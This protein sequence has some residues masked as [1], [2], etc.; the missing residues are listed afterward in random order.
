[1]A[2]ANVPAAGPTTPW[3]L[4]EGDEECPSCGHLYIYEM[5]FHCPEC[6]I[7]ACIHC[8]RRHS[9]GRMVCV[10]CVEVTGGTTDAG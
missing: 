1:M 9:D 5:E 10:S 4:L 3:W 7:T 2:K 6:E 8:R